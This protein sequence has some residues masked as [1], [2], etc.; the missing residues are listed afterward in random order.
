MIS[1]I[2]TAAVYVDDYPI[3]TSPVSTSFTYYGTRKIR[4]VKDGYETLTVERK[5]SPPWYQYFPLD[6]VA[7]NVVPSEIRDESVLDFTL[8]PQMIVPTD[9]LIGRAEQLRQSGR[10]GV[11]LVGAAAPLGSPTLAAPSGVATTGGPALLKP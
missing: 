4:I 7:E 1:K 11:A 8:S 2:A 6:F 5:I 10:G 9:Q 3:G